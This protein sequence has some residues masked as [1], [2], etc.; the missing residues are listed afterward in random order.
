MLKVVLC[1]P[2]HLWV[3]AWPPVSKSYHISISVAL[4]LCAFLGLGTHHFSFISYSYCV[5][6]KSLLCLTFILFSL[7]SSYLSSCFDQSPQQQLPSN[8]LFLLQVPPKIPSVSSRS[9]LSC[10]ADL[11][12]CLH[13]VETIGYKPKWYSVSRM[14]SGIREAWVQILAL[15]HSNWVTLMKLFNFA[16]LR[17]LICRMGITDYTF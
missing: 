16:C 8:F 7:T 5:L 15:L 4:Y 13:C 14:W 2:S 11:S 9:L 10:T 17:C 3:W 1:W 6:A 12:F